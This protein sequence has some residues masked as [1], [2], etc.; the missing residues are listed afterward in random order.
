LPGIYDIGSSSV[1]MRGFID[2]EGSGEN[3]TKIVGNTGTTGVIQ[4][5][6]NAELRFLSVENI[7]GN[8]DAIA[9]HYEDESPRILHVTAKASGGTDTNCGIYLYNPG[10]SPLTITHVTATASG[11]ASSY[12]IW[13]VDCRPTLRNVIAT[14]SG[15]SSE[16]YGVFDNNDTGGAATI[17][18][19][20]ISGTTG[21]I[22]PVGFG[23]AKVA[24]T[25]LEGNVAVNPDTLSQLTCAGV[26]N[27]SFNFYSD[28]CPGL[29][30]P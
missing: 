21:S 14:A 4:G 29:C 10:V 15:S 24:S 20:V 23:S 22:K 8:S 30:P 2:I 7:G 1:V 6:S 16:S 25:R 17:E 12:G 3:I 27:A 13:Y 28:C 5:A 9:I 11:G 19:S 26:W 18:N